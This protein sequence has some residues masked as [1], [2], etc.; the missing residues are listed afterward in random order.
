MWGGSQER[1]RAGCGAGLRLPNLHEH[2]VPEL[3]VQTGVKQLP[4]MCCF[5]F[6]HSIDSDLV[7]LL[8]W[9]TSA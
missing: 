4:F 6:H 5:C 2:E 7:Q 3:P 9:G 8:Y 1:P